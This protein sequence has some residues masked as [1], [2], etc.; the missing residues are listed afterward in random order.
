MLAIGSTPIQF[1]NHLRA[2][3]HNEQAVTVAVGHAIRC[4]RATHSKNDAKNTAA[5][6]SWSVNPRW[7]KLPP[8]CQSVQLAIRYALTRNAITPASRR[9][10]VS[11]FARHAPAMA[12][13]NSGDQKNRPF[14][15]LN[16][17]C[18]K[19]G[20]VKSNRPSWEYTLANH[21]PEA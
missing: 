10:R 11:G 2:G 12:R 8:S 16:S 5:S 7:P 14:W 3:E 15:T 13:N 6:A 20:A 18:L 1:L 4:R 17:T 19:C 9:C 21:W